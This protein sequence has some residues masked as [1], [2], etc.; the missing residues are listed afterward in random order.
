M[1]FSTNLV[2]TWYT[3]SKWKHSTYVYGLKRFYHANWPNWSTTQSAYR[4]KSEKFAKHFS[5]DLDE[6]WYAV[7]KWKDS[8][9]VCDS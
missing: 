7:S 2:E 4:P 1:Y 8:S 6:T 9:H 5:T 3:V